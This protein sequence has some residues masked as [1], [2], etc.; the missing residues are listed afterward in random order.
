MAALLISVIYLCFIS[1]GL[2][3]SLLGSAWPVMHRELDVPVSY[4]GIVTMITC[5][6]TILSGLLSDKL[7]RRFGTW[8]VTV[9]SILLTVLGLFGF[10]FAP[11]FLWLCIFAIPYGFGAGAIDSALNNYIA[12]RFSSRSLSWLHCFWGVGTIISPNIMSFCLARN[13]DWSGGYRIVAYMQIG[14]AVITAF[15]LPLWRRVKASAGEEIPPAKLTMKEK[16]RIPGVPLVLITFFG[17]CAAEATVMSW[18]STYLFRAKDMEEEI[19]A[20]F[21]SL[22]Y[23]GMTVGRFVTGIFADRI[24]DKRLI[25]YG[26][27]V[28][29]GGTV[30]LFL[31]LPYGVSLAAFIIIG[32]GSAPIY[33]AIVHATPANFGRENSQ[34]IIGLEIA[35]A[36]VGSTFMPPLYG[37]LVNHASVHLL[38]PF[39]LA[40]FVLHMVTSELLNRKAKHKKVKEAAENQAPLCEE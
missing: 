9:A 33:P 37:L 10:S 14:I 16:L 21:G 34:A 26:A 8:A 3:D 31:P 40:F 5:V 15:S 1:L 20:A 29:I 32:L 2:P 24:G 11:G 12:L 19:A 18:A 23:I 17:Y 38:P 35:C 7:T 30:L 4:M 36:Y 25:R 22:F 39:L 13:A 27:I 6:T 28:A